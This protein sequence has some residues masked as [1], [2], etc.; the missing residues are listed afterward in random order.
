MAFGGDTEPLSSAIGFLVP[1]L[2]PLVGQWRARYDPSASQNVGAHITLL[3]PF[4]PPDQITTDVIDELGTLFGELSLPLL[5][6]AGVCAFPD[7]VYLLPEPMEPVTAII[8]RL[9]EAYP[10]TPPYGGAVP[11]DR[12]VP[13][14]TLAYSDNPNDL[15]PI[16]EAFCRASI[17]QLPIEA[18]I[19]EALLLVQ[20]E[21]RIFRVKG[22]LPLGR[23]AE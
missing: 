9:A 4:K 12:I 2:E 17:G 3:S 23:A 21:D 8:Q 18:R 10:D 7:V 13:H 15:L 5:Q 16:S 14:V 19:R 22:V 6:F 11:V 20:D 1:E